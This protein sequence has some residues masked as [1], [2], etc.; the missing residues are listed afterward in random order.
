LQ[1]ESPQKSRNAFPT[2]ANPRAVLLLLARTPKKTN[3]RLT[4]RSETQGVKLTAIPL[5]THLWN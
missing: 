5:K 1:S 3:D 4:L 2:A